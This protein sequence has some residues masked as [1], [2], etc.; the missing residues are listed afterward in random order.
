MKSWGFLRGVVVRW[1]FVI[2]ETIRMCLVR[3]I[4]AVRGWGPTGDR[5]GPQPGP[6]KSTN[7]TFAYWIHNASPSPILS[8]WAAV[9][10][11]IS[12]ESGPL[13]RGL[14][15]WS[16]RENSG[17]GSWGGRVGRGEIPRPTSAGYR[18]KAPDGVFL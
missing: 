8:P 5:W 7:K 6:T 18:D 12:P 17:E 11:Q 14:C 9:P 2:L 16:L 13:A 1:G 4:P 15:S 10:A 3:T